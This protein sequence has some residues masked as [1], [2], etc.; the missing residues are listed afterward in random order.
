MPALRGLYHRCLAYPVTLGR[1][2]EHVA[3]VIAP[4]QLLPAPAV[5]P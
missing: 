3:Y 4:P 1:S 5:Q 2:P